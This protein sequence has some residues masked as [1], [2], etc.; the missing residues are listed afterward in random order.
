M[1][2]PRALALL[3]PA[4]L[5]AGW[6]TYRADL[7][8]SGSAP[9]P[10]AVARVGL[11][12]LWTYRSA[13]WITSTPTVWRDLVFVGTWNGDV[14]ALDRNS[15][16]VRWKAS[17]G[18]N[19]DSSYG[20]TRG[21]VSSVSIA[22]ETAYAVSGSCRA[23]AFDATTGRPRWT[24][25]ICSDARNDDTYASPAVGGG[26][27]LLGVDLLDDRPTDRG[28]LIAL[29]ARSGVERWRFVAARYAG[30]GSGVSATPA[31][32]VG[33]GIAY[34]GTGNPLPRGSPP[35]GPDLYSE[36]VVALRLRDGAVLWSYGPVHRHDPQDRD[37]FASPNRFG[38]VFHGTRL[39]AVGEGGKDGVYYAVDARSGRELWRRAVVPQAPYASI[40]G[41]PAV[42]GGS[43]VVPLYQDANTGWLVAL[44]TADGSVRWRRRL[45]GCYEA[46][47]I[48]GKAVFT[49]QTT[50]VLVA[51]ALDDGKLLARWPAG[52]RAF[53]RGPSI[54]GSTLYAAALDRL[55]A[56][57]IGT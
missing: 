45:A 35:A 31:I 33:A 27:V 12:R 57:Q 1:D 4:L 49:T 2:R 36:S 30:M 44:A 55:S 46:P 38:L 18:A 52:P 11:A 17:L 26:L 23:G 24:R 15:G 51:L 40:I 10:A 19:S 14:L 20:Q 29:D 3:F 25:A 5:A 22:A 42:G 54:V 7:A 8:N 56:W 47:T 9:G 32:D 43:I 34:V 50:G 39:E 37:L 48:W 16:R 28:F 53:G 6:P 13:S 21:V 41:T